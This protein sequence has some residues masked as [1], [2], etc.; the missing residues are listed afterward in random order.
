MAPAVGRAKQKPKDGKY[1]KAYSG[2]TSNGP[3]STARAKALSSRCDPE[4]A[5]NLQMKLELLSTTHGLGNAKLTRPL[6]S[7]ISRPINMTSGTNFFG[8]V[9]LTDT[10]N[11]N[12]AVFLSLPT[13]TKREQARPNNSGIDL[14]ADMDEIGAILKDLP[15]GSLG[16][17]PDDK[18]DDMR[19]AIKRRRD[20]IEKAETELGPDYR[21]K[22][23]ATGLKSTAQ[24]S[25]FPENLVANLLTISTDASTEGISNEGM[26]HSVIWKWFTFTPSARSYSSYKC[27]CKYRI[28]DYKIITTDTD[29]SYFVKDSVNRVTNTVSKGA[30]CVTIESVCTMFPATPV[31]LVIGPTSNI[32]DYVK[33]SVGSDDDVFLY[34]Q[35]TDYAGLN[36]ASSSNGFKSIPQYDYIPPNPMYGIK[37]GSVF[38]GYYETRT[39]EN[40]G[41]DIMK[42][43]CQL[44]HK[45]TVS[46]DNATG[47][48]TIGFTCSTE[49]VI[50]KYSVDGDITDSLATGYANGTT[51]DMW[52]IWKNV[53]GSWGSKSILLHTSI[54]VDSNAGQ[55]LDF[56]VPRGM[57]LWNYNEYGK[58]GLNNLVLE[59]V[60]T[61]TVKTEAQ[62]HDF[63]QLVPQAFVD[64][65]GASEVFF[66][67]GITVNGVSI[68]PLELAPSGS[69]TS[70]FMNGQF[71]SKEPQ[72]GTFFT[73]N[74]GFYEMLVTVHTKTT[75]DVNGVTRNVGTYGDELCVTRLIIFVLPDIGAQE[76]VFVAFGKSGSSL[77]NA[78]PYS[79]YAFQPFT[80]VPA[81]VSPLK[82]LG[83]TQIDFSNK[84]VELCVPRNQQNNDGFGSNVMLLRSTRTFRD[85]DRA[86]WMSII[87]TDIPDSN[88][89]SLAT[90]DLVGLD[91]G[92]SASRSWCI[93]Y[94]SNSLIQELV[95]LLV[96]SNVG[97]VNHFSNRVTYGLVANNEASLTNSGQYLFTEYAVANFGKS[98]LSVEAASQVVMLDLA[99]TFMTGDCFLNEDGSELTQLV[100]DLTAE[101]SVPS[102]IRKEV[103]ENARSMRLMAMEY[104]YQGQQYRRFYDMTYV[105]LTKTQGFHTIEAVKDGDRNGALIK[106]ATT[107]YY[108]PAYSLLFIELFPGVNPYTLVN[109]ETIT[110][111]S[112]IGIIFTDFHSIPAG[113]LYGDPDT[114]NLLPDSGDTCSFTTNLETVTI[115][116]QSSSDN[117]IRCYTKTSFSGFSDYMTYSM[118][119]C[120][121][122]YTRAKVGDSR[123]NVLSF[124]NEIVGFMNT[125]CSKIGTSS[126]SHTTL[127]MHSSSAYPIYV[128][129]YVAPVSSIVGQMLW[130]ASKET[131]QA[132]QHPLLP[133]Y[134]GKI[135]E[136]LMIDLQWLELLNS[137]TGAHWKT[138]Y[139]FNSGVIEYPIIYPN[140][141]PDM[142]WLQAN[143][144]VTNH[145][146]NLGYASWDQPLWPQLQY[147]NMVI[148]DANISEVQFSIPNQPS[149]GSNNVVTATCWADGGGV[150]SMNSDQ[151][152]VESSF[153]A[154][155]SDK[156]AVLNW[157]TIGRSEP[158]TVSVD[159][160]FNAN[161][162]SKTYQHDYKYLY[163]N[164]EH[165]NLSPLMAWSMNMT[166]GRSAIEQADKKERISLI[167]NSYGDACQKAANN[168]GNLDDA[169][170]C[171]Y[172]WL[173]RGRI[174]VSSDA[175]FTNNAK[176]YDELVTNTC[177]VAKEFIGNP[178][179]ESSSSSIKTAVANVDLN[180]YVPHVVPAYARGSA[181]GNF[182]ATKEHQIQRPTPVFLP[183]VT[184]NG[185]VYSVGLPTVTEYDIIRAAHHKKQI[186]LALRTAGY[187]KLTET[188]VTHAGSTNPAFADKDTFNEWCGTPAG[189]S[190]I[191]GAEGLGGIAGVAAVLFTISK[192]AN[193]WGR[194]VKWVN[195]TNV[196][197]WAKDGGYDTDKLAGSTLEDVSDELGDAIFDDDLLQ[198]TT[199][200][201]RPTAFGFTMR[202]MYRA[203]N[204]M[205]RLTNTVKG[206]FDS[207]FD[208]CGFLGRFPRILRSLDV[209]RS[210]IGEILGT[211]VDIIANTIS[212]VLKIVGIIVDILA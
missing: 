129:D 93:R 6:F 9:G 101:T 132:E 156:M 141:L 207:L 196:L 144:Q 203:A 104:E 13:S 39:P 52:L 177:L 62:L 8:T 31:F 140:V 59:P 171:P 128:T 120:T 102:H 165:D 184:K 123:D 159:N 81:A 16:T 163:D 14:P 36:Y 164:Y 99:Q 61:I 45:G 118:Y 155:T 34:L 209:I 174:H 60:N 85:S 88:N 90:N 54:S 10:L 49:G 46:L 51:N 158:G 86:H 87:N 151:Y 75:V 122:S 191:Q 76:S 24:L 105:S 173:A 183:D 47:A 26:E 154:Y 96:N 139:A 25:K 100:L 182:L 33:S 170:S 112:D 66:V 18:V 80:S 53:T 42:H 200:Y 17:V 94:G 148:S 37:G 157:F 179:S 58:D 138:T 147:F 95:K 1:P 168:H 166:P 20:K 77:L 125:T 57:D 143:A 162:I 204:T 56:E 136:Y 21:K 176:K 74:R 131:Y 175:V 115:A 212:E 70:S 190:V 15:D 178:N 126:T 97:N 145:T 64:Y 67:D 7:S 169:R 92:V 180:N 153:D 201:L 142:E 146:A 194:Y 195:R 110:S 193:A 198:T 111:T 107:T 108:V 40:V 199:S 71:S 3:A 149:N 50:Q 185:D 82:S 43:L 98:T 114:G 22:H 117:A 91:G 150:S 137:P 103:F 161:K 69:N 202:L 11:N 206:A 19:E 32:Y 119:P 124:Y 113:I 211:L 152:A 134:R 55:K 186:V 109:G 130:G 38:N 44:Y 133:K 208:E 27:V 72:S 187:S 41:A 210:I 189:K 192:V 83:N 79:S 35:S 29:I 65:V 116:P 160:P 167:T 4:L 23:R 188:G 78:L 172:A 68:P 197:K 181:I 89:Y 28:V 12:V 135:L 63:Q 30:I 48:K 2:T 205:K 5:R 73:G 121:A 84:N 127:A 106:Y